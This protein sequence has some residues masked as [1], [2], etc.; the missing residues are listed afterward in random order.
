MEGE[1]ECA[2]CPYCHKPH[3]RNPPILER[4]V[5]LSCGHLL[6]LKCLFHKALSRTP[7]FKC[8]LCDK[9]YSPDLPSNWRDRSHRTKIDA[10]IIKAIFLTISRNPNGLEDLPNFLV[11]VLQ[12]SYVFYSN[13]FNDSSSPEAIAP[14]ELYYHPLLL[15][16]VTIR[17][18][19]KEL[20]T[21][22]L[23]QHKDSSKDEHRRE[24]KDLPTDEDLPTDKNLPT[25]ENLPTDKDSSRDE[26]R[27]KD[28]D[29][30][31]GQQ[32]R[33]FL[34]LL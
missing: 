2:S 31:S 19:N 24:D 17:A 11:Q 25:D 15:L 5:S 22:D 10:A 32:A 8:P 13:D 21:I 9:P 4:P 30:P 14:D 3:K 1:L 7:S 26:Y 12:S 33:T 29:L 16:E 18:E 6:R 23:A 34:K 27:G 20:P 28:E